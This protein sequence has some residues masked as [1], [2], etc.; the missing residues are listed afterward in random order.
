MKPQDLDRGIDQGRNEYRDPDDLSA[1]RG[2]FGWTLGFLAT[3]FVI[4]VVRLM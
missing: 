4:A 1:A 2:I 3:L